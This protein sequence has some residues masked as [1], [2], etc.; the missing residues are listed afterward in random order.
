MPNPRL[1]RNAPGYECFQPKA[2]YDF[3][4]PICID[5]IDDSK[6][7]IQIIRLNHTL[8]KCDEPFDGFLRRF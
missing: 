1:Y 2:V 6:Y 5:L 7:L 3:F 8:F 4:D